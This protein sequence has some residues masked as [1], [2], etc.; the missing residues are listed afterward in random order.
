MRDQTKLS[1]RSWRELESDENLKQIGLASSSSKDLVSTQS[2]F[3]SL[4]PVSLS[5]PKKMTLPQHWD[6]WL[7]ASIG[8]LERGSRLRELRAVSP[9]HADATRVTVD[10]A[11]LAAWRAATMDLGSGGGVSMPPR[12]GVVLPHSDPTTS[13][14]QRSAMSTSTSGRRSGVAPNSTAVAVADDSMAVGLMMM[15]QPPSS[16]SSS[17]LSPSLSTPT[18]TS[19]T[20][21][22]LFS[23][24]DYLGLSTHPRVRQAASQ[25]AASLGCGPRASALVPGAFTTAHRDLERALSRLKGTEDALLFPTG[26]AANA[27]TMAAL[28][29]PVGKKNAEKNSSG[30]EERGEEELVI[31]FSDELN[32]AS[33]VDG[34]RLAARSSSLPSPSDP[35]SSSS[36]PPSP[37][38]RIVIYPHNDIPYLDRDLSQVPRG[39]RKLVVTDSLFS[40]DGDFAD[41]P[42]LCALRRK[43]GF[44]L[45][46]D[47]AH[48]TLVCGSR[49]GGG[50][51]ELFGVSSE[52]DVHVG[53]LSKAFGAHGGFAACSSRLRS[54]LANAGRPF[55]FSTALPAPAVAAALASLEVAAFESG[56]EGKELR[57]RV[58]RHA[59]RVGEALGLRAT[60]PIIPVFLGGEKEALAASGFLLDRG[61]HVP[62]IRPP[63]VPK[64]TSR[65][66]IS[67]S[68]AH[69]D[70]DVGRLIGALAEL[71]LSA[72]GLSGRGSGGGGGRSKL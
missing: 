58:W 34:A 9:A 29:G 7:S 21:L 46:V 30:A 28:C 40:M 10:A 1:Q 8:E 32:H 15:N 23:T 69:S 51:A 42:A 16:A 25:A 14:H 38:V 66:R 71:G 49:C 35:S 70:E 48:A 20:T 19:T 27:A 59:R 43:H 50:A 36:P 4:F 22:T 65:L 55:A 11:T 13:R 47:E 62:A 60:S 5:S 26:F 61:L 2:T 54:L 6:A 24:N 33:I 53:T 39:A 3:F 45:V 64:G 52:I 44:L 18:S 63:T 17:S 72:K 56:V 67:L 12:S 37:R 68:A 41:L 57:D 31:V